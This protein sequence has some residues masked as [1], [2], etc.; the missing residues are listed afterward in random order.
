MKAARLIT[1]AA[2]GLLL[3]ACSVSGSSDGDEDFSLVKDYSTLAQLSTDSS[4]VIV[5]R[6]QGAPVM[7]KADEEGLTKE[8]VP[9]YS[10][11]LDS[12]LKGKASSEVRVRLLGNETEAEY[13]TLKSHGSYLLYLQEFEWHR[14]EG[15]GE[16]VIT[17]Q[18]GAFKLSGAMLSRVGQFGSLPESLSLDEAAAQI[19]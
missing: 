2:A 17:G 6:V 16:Y 11:L 3:T 7:E 1:A 4:L 8:Q 9:V 10:L 12:N 13:P 15:T 18:Q 19:R 5:G 14:G